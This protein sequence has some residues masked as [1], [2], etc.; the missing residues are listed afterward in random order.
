MRI[1]HNALRTASTELHADCMWS[2]GDVAKYLNVSENTIRYWRHVNAGP[3][4][5]K[6]G[7]LARYRPA[8]VEAW[9]ERNTTDPN[10]VSAP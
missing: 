10:P 2:S 6:V 5:I 9:L 4:W 1:L 3:R 7:R 8:D